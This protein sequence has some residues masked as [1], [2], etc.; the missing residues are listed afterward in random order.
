MQRQRFGS[1]FLDDGTKE[2][3]M[4]I[5]KMLSEEGRKPLADDI[6][7]AN[8]SRGPEERWAGDFNDLHNAHQP[9]D[10]LFKADH[11]HVRGNRQ[12]ADIGS[13][14]EF[15][16]DDSRPAGSAPLSAVKPSDLEGKPVI[17]GKVTVNLD[18]KIGQPLS[19]DSPGSQV[20]SEQDLEDRAQLSAQYQVL[21]KQI[22]I[23]TANGNNDDADRLQAQ[24]RALTK[25]MDAIE[26][27]ATNY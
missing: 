26:G 8:T 22:M 10:R 20:A 24:L 3:Q 9:Q 21:M 7:K 5:N 23:A 4:H 6:Q 25:Q 15:R 14:L 27:T 12:L 16:K 2:P 13:P 19:V 18:P 17:P 11:S 1:Q